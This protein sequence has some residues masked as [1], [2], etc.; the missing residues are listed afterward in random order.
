MNS[1]FP[2]IELRQYLLRPR[3]RDEL[4][5]LFEREF[6]ESQEALGMRLF[7]LFC[8]R[9]RPDYFIWLRGLRNMESRR[10][11]LE[12]FYGGPVWKTHGGAANA[13][14]I[15]S[16]NVLLLRD[17]QPWS[18]FDPA[19]TNVPGPLHCMIFPLADVSESDRFADQ[20]LNDVSP[21]VLLGAYVTE[22]SANTFPRLPVREGQYFVVFVSGIQSSGNSSLASR[23]SQIVDLIPTKRSRLQLIRAGSQPP[24]AGSHDFDFSLAA[25][26]F[27]TGAFAIHS[28]LPVIGMNLRRLQPKPLYWEAR[29]TSNNATRLKPQPIRFMPLPCACTALKRINGASTGQEQAAVRLESLLLAASKTMSAS[30][31]ITRSTTAKSFS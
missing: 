5:Q 2:I 21:K 4:I 29:A 27:T 16:D 13:T 23:A 24:A 3:R 28:P 19:T 17:A 22:S 18:G 12:Q 11:V 25:G 8:D 20:F 31:S 26:R 10:A 14:M 9:E 1:E 15:D 7:G 30:S 6:I